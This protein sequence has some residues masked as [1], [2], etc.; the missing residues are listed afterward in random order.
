MF[1]KPA[2]F[3]RKS[4]FALESYHPD[5][6][7]LILAT[8]GIMT[9]SLALP[10]MT[11]QIYDRVLPNE[12]GGTLEVLILGTLLAVFLE[13]S[14]RLCRAYMM[15][16]FGASYEHQMACKA[17]RVISNA[18][19]GKEV[20]QGT[21]EQ[22]H[23]LNAISQLKDFHNGYS[24]STL[25]ELSFVPIA[26]ILI[27]YIAGKLVLVPLSI[28]LLFCLYSLR[29]GQAL[30]IKMQKREAFDDKRFNFLVESLEGVHTLKAF[31]LENIRA[32][33]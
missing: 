30:K 9:L 19:I 16:R 11:L 13:L 21:G 6:A 22:L 8:L 18:N 27:A 1:V 32:P 25:L 31:A 3:T 15:G 24:L 2:G 10:I 26:L 28:L 23:R 5:N 29:H 33:L 17:I 20:S 4:V 12:G 14:L 7:S